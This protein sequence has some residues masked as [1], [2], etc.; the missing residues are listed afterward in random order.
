MLPDFAVLSLSDSFAE[1]WPKLVPSAGATLRT[2]AS[3]AELGRLDGVCGVL[4]SA[5]GAEP[6]VI[7]LI[8]ELRARC[9][10]EVAVT[11]V[12][13]DYRVAITLLRSG[14]SG[15]YAL[16]DDLG[17]LRSWIVERAEQ[18]VAAA[19]ARALAAAQRER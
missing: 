12:D 13:T 2:G 15:Y 8:D 6:D 3:V 4:I 18:V 10:A 9:D 19:N 1:L 17:M 16:P 5:P 14:A 7:P 11:G